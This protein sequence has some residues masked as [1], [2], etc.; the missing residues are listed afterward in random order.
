MNKELVIINEKTDIAQLFK[1]ESIDDI[2]DKIK[3][4][5]ELFVPNVSTDK[6]RKEIASF[7]RKVA[8]SKTLID[9]A[10]KKYVA[11]LKALPKIVDGERKRLRDECDRLR[12]EVRQ[13]LTDWEDMRKEVDTIIGEFNRAIREIAELN[14][15]GIKEKISWL[16]S[17]DPENIVED[18]REKFKEH[19]D[20]AK[21][22]LEN[23]YLKAKKAEEEAAE[24]ERLRAEEEARKRKEAEEARIKAAEQRAREQ[25]EKESR[26]RELKAKLD[27]ELA[28]KRA[29][30]AEERALRVEAEAKDRAARAAEQARR[31]AEERAA[32]EKRIADA[33]EKRKAE[34][35]QQL[36]KDKQHRAEIEAE[37][38]ASFRMNGYSSEEAFRLRALLVGGKIK[39]VVVSYS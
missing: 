23:A 27:K 39:N 1:P 6:G 31:E 24:L 11:E 7:A 18:K 38:E 20:N 28:E 21:L 10:G 9:G 30:E 25:A 36:E 35:K 5:V 4:E 19:L 15:S 22:S 14:S 13:P 26:E 33:E 2:L 32:E 29:K 12:D 17:F 16:N 8:S 37:I 3:K 34:K